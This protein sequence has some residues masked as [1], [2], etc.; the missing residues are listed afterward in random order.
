MVVEEEKVGCGLVEVV[1]VLEEGRQ[2]VAVGEG[3]EWRDSGMLE[4]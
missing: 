3:L 4:S 2:R 1:G